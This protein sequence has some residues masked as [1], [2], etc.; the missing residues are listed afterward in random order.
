VLTERY[1][2]RADVFE[3]GVDLDIYR[4]TGVPRDDHTIVYYARRSTPR[5]ATEMGLLALGEV[6]RRRPGT[7]V[8]LFG[9]TRAPRLP[10]PHEFAGVL[11]EPALARLYCEATA[12]LVISLT[13]YSRMPKEMMACGLPVVDVRHPSVVSAFP[14]GEQVIELADM[15]F[16]SIADRLE[17]LLDDAERRKRLGEAGRNFVQ[18]MTWAAAADQIE[19][20]ARRRLAEHWSA[21]LDG[22][23]SRST[24]VPSARR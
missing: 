4:L 6:V 13:N 20:A 14:A 16:V 19:H 7:R 3:L 11:D 22:D 5:R 2:A 8:V 10:F 18:G 24:S 9:D 15:D 1:G 12:G 23:Q 17:A 21:A